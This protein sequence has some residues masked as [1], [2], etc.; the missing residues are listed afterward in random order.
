MVSVEKCS[1]ILCSSPSFFF[2]FLLWLC[3][4]VLLCV[5]TGAWTLGLGL[6]HLSHASQAFSDKGSFLDS[7]FSGREVS[8]IVEIGSHKG[9]LM[10]QNHK[11]TWALTQL[12][13]QGN[14]NQIC[15]EKLLYTHG[16]LTIMM[17]SVGEKNVEQLKPSQTSVGE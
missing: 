1:I 9:A 6:C 17:W 3:L 5:S 10:T 11:T 8:G 16:K 13:H 7:Y 2:F 4:C 14:T 12:N 15:N